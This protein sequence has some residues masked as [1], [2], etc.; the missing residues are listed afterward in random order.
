[1]VAP[2]I[3]W[4]HAP[5][6]LARDYSAAGGFVILLVLGA[7]KLSCDALLP[8]QLDSVARFLTSARKIWL[9]A[10]LL[11]ARFLIA[12]PLLTDA[13]LRL[14]Q[15]R[16]GGQVD[17]AYHLRPLAMTLIIAAELFAGLAIA[18]GWRTRI[19]VLAILPLWAW[20]AL[21]FHMPP[22]RLMADDGLSI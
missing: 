2:T 4:I 14:M 6:N 5:M 12:L 19:V 20:S 10:G 11:I 7:G 22:L 13:V 9:E 21:T 17:P 3:F 16:I 18:S 1:I 15:M 8:V